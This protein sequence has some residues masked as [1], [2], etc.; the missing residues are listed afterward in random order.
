MY[1]HSL[2]KILN[3]TLYTIDLRLFKI[4]TIKLSARY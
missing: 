3:P 2:Y 1:V 4:L